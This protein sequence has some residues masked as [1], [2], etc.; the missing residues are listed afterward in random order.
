MDSIVVTIDYPQAVH[1]G[2]SLS[3]SLITGHAAICPEKDIADRWQALLTRP[4]PL[5]LPLYLRQEAG[6]FTAHDVLMIVMAIQK[7][8]N[9]AC[10]KLWGQVY[11]YLTCIAAAKV[12]TPIHI[13]L[14]TPR[15]RRAFMTYMDGHDH[16]CGIRRPS[17]PMAHNTY[18]LQGG[19]RYAFA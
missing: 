17:Q 13:D 16:A 14:G 10:A 3:L 15:G 12:P 7:Y 11:T 6:G 8:G 2:Q 1:I 19:I 4:R 9:P 5:T 18:L